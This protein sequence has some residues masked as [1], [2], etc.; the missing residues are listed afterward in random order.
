MKVEGECHCGA[1]T[2][3]AEVEP[4]TMRIC[5][6]RDCQ[7]QSGSAFRTNIPAPAETFRIT[8]GSPRTYVKTADSGAKRI[9]AFC[10]NCG[11]PVY[12]CA[13][14]NPRSFSLRVGALNQGHE[15]G[16]PSLQIW[17]RRRFHW[18]PQ[19]DGVPGTTGQA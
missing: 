4:G 5:H 3:E 16:I 17:T 15:L 10:E 2:Y 13:A 6:C 8:K 9:H 1:V 18:L 14:E 11:G 12:A 19:L 7:R